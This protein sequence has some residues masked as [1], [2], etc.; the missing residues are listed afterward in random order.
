M[1]ARN[2]SIHLKPTSLKPFTEKLEKEIMPLLR[3]QEGFRNEITF[4][5]DNGTNV[6]AIS[7]WDTEA[8]ANQYNTS[9]YPQVLKVLEPVLDGSP[10]MVSGSSIV[11]GA[12]A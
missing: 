6:T 12:T 8:H 4:S 9:G 1:Y 10:T 11:Y 5:D 3:K 7:L 2:L